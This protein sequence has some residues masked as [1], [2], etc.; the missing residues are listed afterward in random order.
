MNEQESSR[1]PK[2]KGMN[3]TARLL[4]SYGEPLMR[5]LITWVLPFFFI[6]SLLLGLW[7]FYIF[8]F[9]QFLILPAGYDHI[10]DP[11]TVQAAILTVIF[12]LLAFL[13]VLSLLGAIFHGIFNGKST[14]FSFN[15]LS[16][17][18]M[19]NIVVSLKQFFRA[20]LVSVMVVLLAY[21]ISAPGYFLG[22]NWM[23]LLILLALFLLVLPIVTYAWFAAFTTDLQYKNGFFNAWVENLDLGFKG[24][25]SI[26]ATGTVA[27]LVIIAGGYLAFL[28]GYFSPWMWAVTNGAAFPFIILFALFQFIAVV[29]FAVSFMW[30]YFICGFTYY[31]LVE[32]LENMPFTNKIISVLG[33][34]QS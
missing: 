25:K 11:D 19:T 32:E 20:L 30:V 33:N 14:D 8:D 6:L 21:L 31:N 13:P 17:S 15:E 1:I 23:V 24:Y 22:Q 3:T 10:I 29:I 9:Q 18:M 12:V 2:I 28:P 27:L 5:V 34:K 26:W 7:F 16:R 4:K